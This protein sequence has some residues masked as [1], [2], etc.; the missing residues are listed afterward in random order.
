M[1]LLTNELMTLNIGPQHP[2]T[3]GGL[4]VEAVLDGEIVTEAIVHL[5]YVHRSVEKI[6]ESKTYTQFIPYTS[7]LDYLASHLPTMGY[8]QAVEKLMG[9]EVPERAEYIRV[10]MA[11]LS[12]IA[13]PLPFYRQSGHRSGCYYRLDLLFPGSRAN[14]GYV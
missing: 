8:V 11:E 4:H 14:N 7:R 12:R 9:I 6:A 2:S 1:T 5:G 10:I 3:H 13:F